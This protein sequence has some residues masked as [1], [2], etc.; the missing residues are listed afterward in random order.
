MR[1][2]EDASSLHASTGQLLSLGLM[3]A[4]AGFAIRSFLEHLWASLIAVGNCF[5]RFHQRGCQFFSAFRFTLGWLVL[6]EGD[7]HFVK[8]F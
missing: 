1:E 8:L 2:R 6:T 7:Q 3:L 5:A 4:V